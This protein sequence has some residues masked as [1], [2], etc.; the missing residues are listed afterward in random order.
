MKDEA[1]SGGHLPWTAQC[2]RKGPS[3]FVGLSRL[4]Q[5]HFSQLIVRVAR[6]LVRK[7]EQTDAL[8]NLDGVEVGLLCGCMRHDLSPNQGNP[9]RRS[10]GVMLETSVNYRAH[11]CSVKEP[12]SF[13]HL[14]Q[15]HHGDTN[16]GDENLSQRTHCVGLFLHA[17]NQTGRGDVEHHAATDGR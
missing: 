6:R 15:N 10:D 16:A 2:S 9:W 7:R 8:E 5:C 11:P 12:L 14:E 1:Q 4:E 17:R 13:V 3:L